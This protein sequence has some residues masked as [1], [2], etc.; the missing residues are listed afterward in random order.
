MSLP[1]VYAKA[2]AIRYLAAKG[3]YVS[4]AQRSL[5]T[6]RSCSLQVTIGRYPPNRLARRDTGLDSPK[7]APVASPGDLRR[8]PITYWLRLSRSSR[9]AISTRRRT[10]GI[11]MRPAKS[12][13]IARRSGDVQTLPAASSSASSAAAFR[14]CPC[15]VYRGEVSLTCPDDD[16]G[17]K[18]SDARSAVVTPS[19]W[20]RHRFKVAAWNMNPSLVNWKSLGQDPR[21]ADAD[22]LLL[23]EILPCC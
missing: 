6:R 2:P 15:P 9:G 1:H 3:E 17:E 23:C 22:V 7:F 13:K 10:G 11:F 21:L 12:T 8:A 19:R 20:P 5:T 14:C 16:G 4:R 18:H